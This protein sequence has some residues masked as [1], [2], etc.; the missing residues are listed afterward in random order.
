MWCGV[1]GRGGVGSCEVVRS[2][3]MCG[4]RRMVRRIGSRCGGWEAPGA[5][6][7]PPS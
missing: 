2:M 7:M 6:S 1:V 5:F 3:A 4:V